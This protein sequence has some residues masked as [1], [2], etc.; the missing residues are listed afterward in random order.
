[1][2]YM[3][4]FRYPSESTGLHQED[5]ENYFKG[6]SGAT[7]VGTGASGVSG[8]HSYFTQGLQSAYSGVQAGKIILFMTPKLEY[9]L[10]IQKRNTNQGLKYF[11]ID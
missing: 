7:T 4:L 11:S 6:S 9:N 5:L 2:S 8:A 1:M 10:G 3:L